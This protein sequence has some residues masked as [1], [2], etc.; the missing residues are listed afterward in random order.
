LKDEGSLGKEKA[1][2]GQLLSKEEILGA[3]DIRTVDVE[4]PEWPGKDGAPGIVR[5]R[6]MMAGEALELVG[7]TA[8]DVKEA[9]KSDVAIRILI[10]CAVDAQDRPLFTMDDLAKLKT[11]N[12]R[13]VLRLQQAALDLNGLSDKGADK[14]KNV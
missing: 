14:T 3:D 12:S 11:K 9:S 7:E 1:M 13:A 8:K 4:V 2:S 5:L 6:A 10:R